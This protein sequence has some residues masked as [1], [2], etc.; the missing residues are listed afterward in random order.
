[1]GKSA[2]DGP[3]FDPEDLKAPGPLLL[4]LES[5]ALWEYAALIAAIPWLRRLPQGDGHPVIVLPG[6]GAGDLTTLPLRAFLS[7]RG[8]TP[9]AWSQ[10][11]NLGPRQGVLARL[12]AL[13]KEVVQ[14]HGTRVSLVGWSLGGVYARELAKEFTADVRC[15]ITLGSPF[16]GHPCATNARLL[17]EFLNEDQRGHHPKKLAQLRKAPRVPTTS[18]YSRTDGIVAWQCSINDPEPHTEN[19][20]VQASHLGMGLNPLAL[21]AIADRLRQDPAKWERFDARGAWPWFFNTDDQPLEA[22]D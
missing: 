4:L 14:S 6:L 10:G 7:D 11:F 9:Y 15:V 13:V 1:M 17:F 22:G 18:I 12:R 19:I 21:F 5:R 16:A 8:Y 2:Y 20:E 3:R